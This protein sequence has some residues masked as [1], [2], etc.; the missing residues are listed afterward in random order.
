MQIYLA[1][2]WIFLEQ[3]NDVF[4]EAVIKKKNQTFKM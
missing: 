4:P 1:K 3:I 2:T